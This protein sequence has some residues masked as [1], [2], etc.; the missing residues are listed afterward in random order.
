VLTSSCTAV[1][2]G[3]CNKNRVFDET[4]WTDLSSKKVE[5][6]ARSKTVAERWAWEYWNSLPVNRRFELTVLN[7]T[8][9]C[10]PVLS[11]QWHG[12]ALILKRMMSFCTF[13]AAPHVSLGVVDVRDV[14]SA[15]IRA[16]QQPTTNGQRILITAQPSLWFADFLNVLRKEFRSQGYLI[17]P[18][19]V[20]KFAYIAYNRVTNDRESTATEHRVGA[21]LKFDNSKSKALL[22]MHY[23]DPRQA[24]L[25]QAYSMIENGMIRK[26]RKYKGNFG[27]IREETAIDQGKM[28]EAG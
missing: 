19:T 24:I 6:Y 13:L 9:I 20:P 5:Y 8:Y 11:D 7:P 21:E 16:M 17:S 14:A 15:H 23:M 1:N 25:D 26:G 2:D 18:F 3:H 22:D 4:S 10:G 12:S 27:R 28:T